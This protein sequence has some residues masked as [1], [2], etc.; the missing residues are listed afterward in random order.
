LIGTVLFH[1]PDEV[2]DRA[3]EWIVD[4]RS[5]LLSKG[6]VTAFYQNLPTAGRGHARQ[7]E[8]MRRLWRGVDPTLMLDD[9]PAFERLRIPKSRH[10]PAGRVPR[11]RRYNL[12]QSLSPQARKRE[13]DKGMAHLSPW[14]DG[15][16]DWL[17]SGW[18]AAE[19][20]DRKGELKRRER[21]MMQLE[22]ERSAAG[23]ALHRRAIERIIADERAS[24]P[25]DPHERPRSRTLWW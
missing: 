19:H 20:A 8:L 13:A 25:I 16:W 2:L 17:F 12:S 5:N 10:Q 14:A 11:G 3:H 15:A 4:Y 7:W 24:W 18:E 21:Q 23:D 1:V 9:V 22:A 6:A